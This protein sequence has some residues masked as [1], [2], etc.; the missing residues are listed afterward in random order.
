MRKIVF[1]GGLH[2]SGTSILHNVISGSDDVS[3]F[4][5]TGVPKNEGQH[6]QT[7][8]KAA[9]VFG[10]PGKF[11]L[12]K[13]ARL[14]ETSSLISK[15]NKQKLWEEWSKYWDTEKAV[16]V[17]KSPPNIIRMRFLQALFPQA[18]FITIIRHPIAVTIATQKWIPKT[19]FEQLIRHWITAHKIYQEDSPKI[20]NQLCISYEYMVLHPTAAIDEIEQFL[21]IKIAYKGEFINMNTRYFDKWQH[22]A[23]KA[24]SRKIVQLKC[25]R[26]YEDLINEFDYSLINLT[27]FPKTTSILG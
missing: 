21:E 24:Y 12:N 25:I 10:G 18:Y 15:E 26:I 19:P 11:A 16:L 17:E 27:A 3:G 6:L 20:K 4:V 8:Y 22:I 2:R 5:S 14:D 7:V 23:P 9:K 1:I 13:N